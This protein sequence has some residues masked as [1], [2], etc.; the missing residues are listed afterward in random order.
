[1][2]RRTSGDTYHDACLCN[3]HSDVSPGRTW[4]M[5]RPFNARGH[6]IPASF[7]FFFCGCIRQNTAMEDE[8]RTTYLICGGRRS[9]Y[10]SQTWGPARRRAA[11]GW[12]SGRI[13]TGTG[14]TAPWLR[15]GCCSSA[16]VS[17]QGT[18]GGS[19]A[20]Q[21]VRNKGYTLGVVT[22]GERE[23]KAGREGVM[24]REVW[25]ER[26]E[27]TPFSGGIQR[28]IGFTCRGVKGN[29]RVAS[30]SKKLRS[31]R[32]WTEI[33]IWSCDEKS[34]KSELTANFSSAEKEKYLQV[35]ASQNAFFLW[36]MTVNVLGFWTP[37]WTEEATSTSC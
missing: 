16:G 22:G 36:V 10:L 20:L 25:S 26:L 12:G 27:V 14:R 31:D 32:L 4:W 37:D 28:L 8:W 2:R 17:L 18:G 6:V 1:M 13:W 33:W 34:I 11:D 21:S 23:R 9:I 15:S 7:F 35:S 3:G 5:R 19:G 30:A 24:W 29:H